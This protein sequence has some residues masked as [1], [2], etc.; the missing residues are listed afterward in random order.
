MLFGMLMPRR[1]PKE[2]KPQPVMSFRVRTVEGRHHDLA[3]AGP[4]TG[5]EMGDEVSARVLRGRNV[6]QV[7]T[8][9]NRTT[10][11]RFRRDGLVV[12]AVSLVLLVYIGVVLLTAHR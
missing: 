9:Q 6:R 3:L 1:G 10:G 8:L 5:I 11:S 2:R 7:L 12:A 4:T